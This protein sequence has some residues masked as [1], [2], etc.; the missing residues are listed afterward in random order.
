MT[1]QLDWGD[2]DQ[3]FAVMTFQGK[4]TGDE[5]VHAIARLSAMG[6]Q[7]STGMELMVDMRNSLNPPN[8][9]LTLLRSTLNRPLPKNIK[10]VVVISNSAFWNRIFGMLKSMYG[11]KI[12]APVSFVPSVDAAY[13]SLDCFKDIV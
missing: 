11:G 5:F 3:N 10:Q 2:Y 6:A 12:S 4:W 13:D 1:I 9:L 7:A 8:N